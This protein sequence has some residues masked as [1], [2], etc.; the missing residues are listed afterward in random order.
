VP[1][2]AFQQYR[3][4]ACASMWKRRRPWNVEELLLHLQ[5]SDISLVYLLCHSAWSLNGLVA[6]PGWLRLEVREHSVGTFRRMKR[7]PMA[8]FAPAAMVRTRQPIQR[9]YRLPSRSLLDV[10]TVC[11]LGKPSTLNHLT[12]APAIPPI[13]TCK[14]ASYIY[15]TTTFCAHMRAYSALMRSS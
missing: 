2:G 10:P 7:A 15:M 13:V 5:C 11:L 4:G 6:T 8:S 14:T 9:N 3:S 12:V 1:A